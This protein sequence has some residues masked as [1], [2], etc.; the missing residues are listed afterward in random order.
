MDLFDV[1]KQLAKKKQSNEINKQARYDFS[2]RRLLLVDD[3][4]VNRLVARE[5]LE[6]SGFH[7]DF[8]VNGQ[9]AVDAVT[10]DDY[11]VVLMDIQ[12]PVMDGL[13]AT[14]EIRKKGGRF[15]S[16]PII[17][18][19]A[20]ALSGDRE[21]SL[22]AG[23]DEH[24]TKPIDLDILYNT[25]ARFVDHSGVKNAEE[26]QEKQRNMII[27][28][29]EGIDGVACMERLKGNHTL[30]LSIANS[31]ANDQAGSA[32]KIKDCIEQGDL[33]EATR[34]AHTLKG[35][36]A[37]IGAM[38]VSEL[39]AKIEKKFKAGEV[40]SAV[41]HLPELRHS[42][43]ALLKA[44]GNYI[45]CFSEPAEVADE[46]GSGDI[47]WALLQ[48]FEDNLMQDLGKAQGSLDSLMKLPVGVAQM[49]GLKELNQAFSAFDFNRCLD[50]I[51]Q[52]RSSKTES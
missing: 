22:E 5:S 1:K 34:I 7:I 49:A 2:G 4:E 31:Y 42:L 26:Q 9:E 36:S 37:N 35:T 38:E 13:T 3:N 11:D 23:L 40:E 16:L 8:C 50:L 48:V 19:T 20:H 27:P 21:K 30:F 28:E 24:I 39:A 25:L 12:M 52:L 46:A 29:V 43:N 18:M 10:T 44:L 41:F 33:G 15:E 6:G 45:E 17:A 14:Q 51:E 32:E 47:D